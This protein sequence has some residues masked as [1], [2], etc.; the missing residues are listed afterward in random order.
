LTGPQRSA[1]LT[2]H[3]LGTLTLVSLRSDLSAAQQRKQLARLIRELPL[4]QQKLILDI[5]ALPDSDARLSQW[6]EFAL[7][8]ATRCRLELVL[9]GVSKPKLAYLELTRLSNL[10]PCYVSAGEAIRDSVVEP[11]N[12]PCRLGEAVG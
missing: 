8:L 9:A 7:S 2:Q 1:F 11:S 6:L 3:Q 10:V 4:N 12:A 5:S